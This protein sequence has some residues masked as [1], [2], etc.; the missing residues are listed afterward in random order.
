MELDKSQ[1]FTDGKIKKL[2]KEK[3]KALVRHAY[4]NVPYYR[5]VFDERGLTWKDINSIEDLEKLPV[6]TKNDLQNMKDDL[7]AHNYAPKNLDKSATG[8]STGVP[9]SFVMDKRCYDIRKA[10]QFRSFSW[11]GF[12]FGDKLVTISSSPIDITRGQS[13]YAKLRDAALRMEIY[14]AYNL[15]PEKIEYYTNK[16]I[17]DRPKVIYGFAKT[18][19]VMAKHIID[20]GVKN[21]SPVSVISGGELLLDEERSKIEEAFNCKVYDMYGSRE[22]PSIATECSA[23][24]GMH[25]SSDLYIIELTTKGETVHQHE[26]EGEITITDL[27]NYAMP[28]IRY[29]IEDLGVFL[30]EGKCT[31]GR[32]F[33]K[34]AI[35]SGRK[36]DIIVTP[37]GNNLS[38]VFFAHLFKEV[39]EHVERYQIIQSSETDLKIN[40]VKR[41]SYQDEITKFLME[42][43]KM[44]IGEEMNLS[45]NFLSEIPLSK[46][47]KHRTTINQVHR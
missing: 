24:D 37:S 16:L 12:D 1:W 11:A 13:L 15:P 26:E 31:C 46:S 36:G 41:K 33:E 35:T 43:I 23:H 38:G 18:L 45:I 29:N 9:T 6:L 8:G 17:H 19:H 25:V 5:R 3:L 39:T 40:I 7:I 14:D 10:A 28:Y 27:N 47:G 20:N 4:E 34:I 22:A 44:K 42:K 32:H 2:Q 30:P 21:V